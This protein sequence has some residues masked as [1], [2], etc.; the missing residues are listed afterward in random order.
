[1]GRSFHTSIKRFKSK[2]AFVAPSRESLKEVL[3]CELLMAAMMAMGLPTVVHA[4]CGMPP[5]G[6]QREQTRKSL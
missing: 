5:N 2:Y 1:M 3:D 4:I 6:K